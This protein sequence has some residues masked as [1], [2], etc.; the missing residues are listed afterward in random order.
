[1]TTNQNP[2]VTPVDPA[3]ALVP[4]KKSKVR[5]NLILAGSAAGLVG[6]GS[7]LAANINLN[8]GEN[9]EFGQGVARTTACDEDGFSINPVTSYDNANS[10]F[11]LDYVEIT[12]LNLTPVG[13]GWDD[14]DLN[15]QYS[16][17]AT[18][19]AAHPGEYFDG[20]AN[21][22]KRTCDGVVLDFK[23]FTDDTDY[24]TSTRDGYS[25]GTT[26]SISTPIGWSQY[27]G[28]A[29]INN[30]DEVQNFGFAVIFDTDDDNASEVS[31]WAVGEDTQWNSSYNES[32]VWSD[33]DH[34]TP[35]N[36]SFK[37]GSINNG[38]NNWVQ[39]YRPNAAAI[40][41]ITV[42]SMATFPSDYYAYDGIGN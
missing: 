40:S 7:T 33:L 12:G 32:T 25:N 15:G 34:S 21:V 31:N 28:L 38:G 16:D 10:I 4:A 5:R 24:W 36:S 23:A 13:T 19:K 41:K 17:T 27:D 9:V 11:R 20:V 37:F 26:N 18:A 6:I 3:A 22:W 39:L 30:S 42:A 14:G 35:A 1:M 29:S 2:E 8:S